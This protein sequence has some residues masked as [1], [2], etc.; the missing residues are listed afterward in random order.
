MKVTT[1]ET[2]EFKPF[3]I[4]VT[5]ESIDELKDLHNRLNLTDDVVNNELR[6]QW[7]NNKCQGLFEEIENKLEDNGINYY[8]APY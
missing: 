1:K 8:R 4:E 3:T 5:V 6:N 7:C 2:N